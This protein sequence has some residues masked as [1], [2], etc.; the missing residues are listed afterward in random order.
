[1]I[2]ML[3]AVYKS[4]EWDSMGFVLVEYCTLYLNNMNDVFN[5]D[6]MLK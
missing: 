3:F 2:Y 5:I 4:A 1:M 6:K